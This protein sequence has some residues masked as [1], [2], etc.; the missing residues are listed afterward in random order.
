MLT[1]VEHLSSH[2][3]NYG[4][5]AWGQPQTFLKLLT[6][7]NFAFPLMIVALIG[8]LLAALRSQ[9]PL[10]RLARLMVAVL[11]IWSLT[12]ASDRIG[13]FLIA[14]LCLFTGWALDQL[15][16]R[17]WR[18]PV[19]LTSA[20]LV[21]LLLPGLVSLTVQARAA[22]SSDLWYPPTKAWLDSGGLAHQASIGLYE[23]PDPTRLPPFPFLDRQVIMLDK[24]EPSQEAPKVIMLRE[25]AYQRKWQRHPLNQRYQITARLGTVPYAGWLDYFLVRFP[26]HAYKNALVLT[27]K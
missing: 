26:G 17:R 24:W 13:L 20:F 5:V 2:G 10:T 6:L 21:L 18:A 15:L 7:K 22:L 8:V 19:W 11:V 1:T 23:P 3:W 12:V 14:P 9:G 27:P 16:L 4:T 25:E